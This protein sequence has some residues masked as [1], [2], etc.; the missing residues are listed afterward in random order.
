M[1]VFQGLPLTAG[2]QSLE[3]LMS[4]SGRLECEGPNRH[5]YDFTG[6]LRL[7]NLK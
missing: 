2:L 7:E 1:C 6:T 3:E 5:L 4:L